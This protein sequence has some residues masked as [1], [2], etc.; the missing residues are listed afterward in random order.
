[1]VALAD[2]F[3]AYAE[4]IE[5]LRTGQ[6]V[7][8]TLRMGIARGALVPSDALVRAAAQLRVPT[9]GSSVNDIFMEPRVLERNT[10]VACTVHIARGQGIFYAEA[11]D[12]GDIDVLTPEV[13]TTFRGG[14]LIVVRLLRERALLT[15]TF[16][17]DDE[18]VQRVFQ[19]NSV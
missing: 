18:S 17:K 1:M 9:L 13:R 8:D 11:I 4:L 7:V 5:R 15:V 10:L 14:A 6:H 2:A 12:A 3:V 19:L 16:V